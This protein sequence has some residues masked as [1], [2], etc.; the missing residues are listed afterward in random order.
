MSIQVVRIDNPF[1]RSARLAASMQY[2]CVTVGELVRSNVAAG[3]NVTASVNGQIIPVEAWSSTEIRDGDCLV[4]LSTVEGNDFKQIMNAIVMIGLTVVSYGLLGAGIGGM[5][6]LGLTGPWLIGA[7]ALVVLAGG[8]VLNAMTPSPKPASNLGDGAST[9]Y[10]WNN[11]TTQQAGLPVPVWY[12]ENKVS[13]NVITAYTDPTIDNSSQTLHALIALGR[14]PVA[15]ISN[16]KINDQ[17]IANYVYDPSEGE[18]AKPIFSWNVFTGTCGQSAAPGG[19]KTKTEYDATH[20]VTKAGGPYTHSVPWTGFDE[21]EVDI[22]LP[23]LYKLNEWGDVIKHSVSLQVEFKRASDPDTD[24][25]WR[26]ATLA[27]TLN[28]I[29]GITLSAGSRPVIAASIAPNKRRPSAQYQKGDTVYVEN[30]SGM[31]ELNNRQWKVYASTT[32]HVTL[33]V[34]AAGFG[35]YTGGGTVGPITLTVTDRLRGPVRRTFGPMEAIGEV[36]HQVRVTKLTAEHTKNGAPNPAFAE[37]VFLQTV[38]T[39]TVAPFRYPRLAYVQFKALACDNLSGSLNFSCTMQGKFVR[40]WDGT[41]WGIQYSNNPAWV[42][43]DILTQPVLTGSSPFAP[44]ATPPASPLT[45][46]RYDGIDPSRIDTAKFLE[47]A[48]YCDEAVYNG[49]KRA[50][51]NGGFDTESTLWETVLRVCEVARCVPVWNGTRMTLAIDKPGNAVQLFTVGNI[52][53]DSYKETFLPLADRATEIEINY[54]DAGQ[55]YDR[56]TLTIFDPAYRTTSNKVSL[57]LVGITNAAEAWRAGMFRLNQ[58]RLLTRTVEFSADIDAI[59]CTI[60]DLVHVQHDVP[61]WGN[62]GRLA[63]ATATTATLDC[64]P[65]CFDPADASIETVVVTA[66]GATPDPSGTYLH[67]GEYLGHYVY[68]RVGGGRYIWWAPTDDA[69]LMSTTA[70]LYGTGGWWLP[71]ASLDGASWSTYGTGCTGHPSSEARIDATKY[72]LM[73]RVASHAHAAGDGYEDQIV[74]AAVVKVDGRAVTVSPAFTFTP[75]RGDVFAF[76]KTGSATKTFRVVNISKDSDQRATIAGIEYNA[77]IYDSDDIQPLAISDAPVRPST[78]VTGLTA[79]EIARLGESG[80][81]ERR[82]QIAWTVPQGTR[83]DHADIYAQSIGQASSWERIG[84]SR[85]TSFEWW[86]VNPS[87]T[88][89]IK[90]IS[91]DAEGRRESLASAPAATV[92]TGSTAPAT[93]EWLDAGVTGLRL[94]EDGNAATFSGQEAAFNWNDMAGQPQSQDADGIAGTSTPNTWLRDYEVKMFG[95]DGALRCTEYVTQPTYLYTYD[96]NFAAGDGVPDRQLII[97]VRA[98]DRYYHRSAVPARLTVSNPAPVA[99]VNVVTTGKVLGFSVRWDSV[100]DS[101][102]AGYRVHASQTLGFV[103]SDSNLVYEG[104]ATA[105]DLAVTVAG[106]WYVKVAAY[107]RFGSGAGTNYSLQTPVA[108]AAIPR[109]ELTAYA[110]TQPIVDGI[111]FAV[112]GT[113]VSWSQGTIS[114]RGASYSVAAGSTT[115]PYIYFDFM[116]VAPTTMSHSATPPDIGR[117]ATSDVWLFCIREASGKVNTVTS[118]ALIHALLIQAGAI[119]ADKLSVATLSAIT[120]NLGSVTAGTITL[121]LGTSNRLRI[122]TDGIYVS[123]DSGSTWRRVVGVEDGRV[124]VSFD[125]YDPGESVSAVL[126]STVTAITRDFMF[127][128]PGIAAATIKATSPAGTT[129]SPIFY[130]ILTPTVVT[131][132]GTGVS[133]DDFRDVEDYDSYWFPVSANTDYTISHSLGCDFP[134]VTVW[135]APDD[136]NGAPDLSLAIANAGQMSSGY[137]SGCFA[138]GPI[139]PYEITLRTGR[140]NAVVYLAATHLRAVAASG[141]CRVI[142]RRFAMTSTYTGYYADTELRFKAASTPPAVATRFIK[143]A[144]VKPVAIGDTSQTW[145]GVTL[146]ANG[147]RFTADRTLGNGGDI[148]RVSIGSGAIPAGVSGY[149]GVFEGP[150]GTASDVIYFPGCDLAGPLVS[151]GCTVYRDHIWD[152]DNPQTEVTIDTTQLDMTQW[153]KRRRVFQ[154]STAGTYLLGLGA[155]SGTDTDG[156]QNESIICTPHVIVGR[157]NDITIRRD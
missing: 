101:D 74:T 59:A 64:A 33:D 11:Q 109:Q 34:N 76:G 113:T 36:E 107:D 140:Q 149:A 128:T 136:G 15:S 61:Q 73:V 118:N 121:D 157:P 146:T 47:L 63:A 79:S 152:W 155:A 78:T 31:V 29:T 72:Q 91:V 151:T 60:G 104:M 67:D 7:T 132:H 27:N 116:A 133:V 89:A 56:T 111:V 99:P 92:T 105:V 45:V 5:A 134:H 16:L 120:A 96:K 1:D 52:G 46:S 82:V 55:N 125:S 141:W 75:D 129:Y 137:E 84:E 41:N 35:A 77:S 94:G 145:T 85:T 124:I 117:S 115:D 69:W 39:V 22:T 127:G 90:V 119:T 24:Q 44:G 38:R 65:T 100:N 95:S 62:G 102:L 13:G 154:F 98:R 144:L 138:M 19:G 4:I 80:S 17:P 153:Q 148:V 14:G 20:K 71:G 150:K 54:R 126:S 9:A 40:V 51:F 3:V 122:D 18:D 57:D 83:W 12:G 87:T 50:T 110:L 6:G 130:P 30:V 21:L 97:E 2:D 103:P 58:N 28:P 147:S 68:K 43:Y 112:A 88:Y 93:N 49:Q 66:N 135:T 26:A 32:T 48:E 81:V 23:S 53:A 8:L 86:D 131:T 37:D 106:D 70:T 10:G 114:Y 139:S 156:G 25:Y 108:V 123:A 42:L 142:I 143:M